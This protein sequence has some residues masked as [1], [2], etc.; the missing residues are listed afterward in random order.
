MNGAFVM[1]GA[2]FGAPAR[3]WIDRWVQ[4]FVGPPDGTRM[5]WGTLVVNVLGSFILGSL[6]GPELP[7]RWDLALGVGFCGSFTTFST[8]AAQS[9]ALRA[10]GHG[11]LAWANVA[12]NTLA[13]VGAATVGY[14]IFR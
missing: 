5:P 4:R 9:D 8:F 14:L 13:C 10:E 6:I 3:Y 1:L 2:L 7:V 12:V 11:D